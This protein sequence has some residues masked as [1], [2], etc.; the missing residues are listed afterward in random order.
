MSPPARPPCEHP[1]GPP[2]RG[3]GGADTLR[4]INP[5]KDG[6]SRIAWTSVQDV[7]KD[8]GDTQ[9]LGTPAPFATEEYVCR[10]D[11]WPCNQQS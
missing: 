11:A 9:Q 2:C 4:S 1:Q 8:E 3:L 5:D 7:N 10:S 6:K